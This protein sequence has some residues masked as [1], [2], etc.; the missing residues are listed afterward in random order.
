MILKQ[1]DS[2][3]HGLINDPALVG[4]DG[5]A[6]STTCAGCATASCSCGRPTR[7]API[8]HF[9]V[10][11]LLGAVDG[12]DLARVAGILDA[13]AQAARAVRAA[14]RAPARRR[15]ARRRRSAR[16]PRCAAC[17]PSARRVEIVADEWANTV[18]DIRAFNRAGAAD[19]IQ[20]KAPDLGSVHNIVD[21]VLDCRRARRRRAH[22]RLVLRDRALGAGLRAP[23]ARRRTPTSCSPS[24]AWAW[25]RACSIVR[26]EME[27][28]LALERRAEP[29]GDPMI[30][31]TD[32]VVLVTGAAGGIGAAT[33]R[34]IAALRRRRRAARPARRRS[35]RRARRRARRP[36][37]RGRRRPRGS[38]RA[39]PALAAGAGLARPR[40]RADQQRRD[41]RAGVDRRAARATGRRRGSA[42]SRSASS[43]PRRCA[44]RRSRLPRAGRRRHDRQPRQ[45]RR[46]A[47]RG[48]RLLALRGREGR[49]RR[50]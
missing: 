30:D 45:P 42:C 15:L 11:G 10:Y 34:T 40:R 5:S 20:I 17:S 27:R 46:L 48:P 18:E 47:R 43:R 21:A 7:Y 1:V 35:P 50:A 28:T 41:L 31:F 29:T 9:D 39:A 49:H 33:A 37:P 2:L 44:A 22:R 24:R 3:P 38:E 16:W 19:V 14:R 13:M 36:R 6:L 26:N 8:L 4:E 32:R 23:R 12:G 25:T